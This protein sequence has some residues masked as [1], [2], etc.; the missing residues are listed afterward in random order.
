MHPFLTN[1]ATFM[2]NTPQQAMIQPL[3]SACRYRYIKVDI[4]A[5]AIDGLAATDEVVVQQ[6]RPALLVGI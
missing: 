6:V 3:R 2:A 1:D 4:H 5:G